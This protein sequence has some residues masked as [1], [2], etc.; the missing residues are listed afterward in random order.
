MVNRSLGNLL[1]SLSGENPRQWD[2]VLAHTKFTYNDSMNKSTGKSPFQIVYGRSPKGVVYLV[3]LHD[4][5]DKRSVNAS[6]FADIMHE[7]HEKVK[8][9][10]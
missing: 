8:Q 6:D 1:R 9:K 3:D 7:L 2:S 4:T 10:L 5:R